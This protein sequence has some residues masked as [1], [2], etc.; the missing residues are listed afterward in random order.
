MGVRA[1]VF[2]C[3]FISDDLFVSISHACVMC[4]HGLYCL[5]Q[6]VHLEVSYNYTKSSTE[7]RLLHKNGLPMN[8]LFGTF[9]YHY[10]DCIED[11]NKEMFQFMLVIVTVNDN[12]ILQ[13]YVSYDHVQVALIRGEDG[14]TYLNG[15]DQALVIP[16]EDGEPSVA[17]PGMHVSLTHVPYKKSSA[18]MLAQGIIYL[19]DV[20]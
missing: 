12:I 19:V 1:Y 16:N 17:L 7:V 3:L 20:T 6:N 10:V 4:S 9:L 11:E 2:V 13:K 8:V 5:S 14:S 15:N 18:L